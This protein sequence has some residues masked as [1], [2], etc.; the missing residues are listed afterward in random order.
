MSNRVKEVIAVV[1]IVAF[2]AVGSYGAYY[3]W[4]SHRHKVL[5]DVTEVQVVQDK[6]DDSVYHLTY[7]VEVKNWWF[8]LS[9]HI[10]RLEYY[11]LGGYNKWDF[12][13]D[14]DY[15]T[16]SNRKNEFKIN[17][18]FDIDTYWEQPLKKGEEALGITPVS[19]DTIEQRV[20]RQ[21]ITYSKFMAYDKEGRIA[22]GSE[23]Y[24]ADNTDVIIQFE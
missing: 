16:S 13:G 24:M 5:Y 17:A 15:F 18:K 7:N 8:D 19:S 11:D 10:Y 1:L 3:M 23:L 12:T 2:L 20:I 9:K 4:W 21:V 22:H 6:K 14:T